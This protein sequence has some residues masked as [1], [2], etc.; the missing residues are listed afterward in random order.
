V[1]FS[2]LNEDNLGKKYYSAKSYTRGLVENFPE[3]E[4]IARNKPKENTPPE[5][6][7]TTDGTTASIIRKTGK[8]VVQQ[9]PTGVVRADGDKTWLTVVAEF[10]YTTEILPYA[11]EEY[12]LI[13]KCW[14]VIEDGLTFGGRP[15]YTPF[16][17]HSGHFSP[18]MVLPYW[19]DIFIQPGKKSGYAC[20]Y[21]FMRSWW[22]PEDIESIIEQEKRLKTQAS[23]RGEKYEGTWDL[24]ALESIKKAKSS[25]DDEAKQPHEEELSVDSD[26]VEI[27]TAFQTGVNACFYTFHPSGG[28]KNQSEVKILRKK[29]NK[30]PRGKMP[31]DWYYGDMDG[32]NPL[33]RGIVELIG[34]LQDLI[35]RNMQ[36]FEFN[37]L[38]AMQPPI[39]KRGSFSKKRIVFAPNVIID[40]GT[41]QQNS[42]D[43]L[44]VDTTA[45]NTYPELYG[46]KK[47]QMLNLVSSPDTSISAEVGNPGFGKT[48]SAI[49]AQQTTVSVDDNYT[50]KMFE[51]TFGNWSETAINLYFAE[52]SGV[53]ELQLDKKTAD[54]LRKLA[55]EEKFDLTKLTD[56]NKIMIDYDTDTPALSF[57]VDAS[58]SKMKD[59]AAQ[60][61]I[62]TDLIKGLES[63]QLLTQ[64][65][66][67]E[68]VLALWNR[69][70]TNSG[71]EDPEDMSIDI[72]EF[73]QQ[74]QQMAE[75]Q[76]AQA[77]AM[78]QPQGAPAGVDPNQ[79]QEGQVVGQ[80]PEQPQQEMPQEQSEAPTAVD[81]LSPD[82]PLRG[83]YQSFIEQ[84]YPPELAVDGVDMAARGASPEEVINSMNE[85]LHAGR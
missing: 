81:F 56:D 49:N 51:A 82:N 5:F 59:D 83:I 26:A 75:Q 66:P 61:Q 78:G 41:D 79:V 84:G 14:S 45:I 60:G 65:V 47:S 23:A 11:N 8:R 24:D 73:K 44:K 18:D 4:R 13:Q 62:L 31:I 10:I 3:Y 52:R 29:Y 32:T 40:L 77:Q 35:D 28:D 74:Q 64:V 43:T 58:T 1:I 27:I 54:Q 37:R 21:I 2:F 48:P 9:L 67:P 68:K 85:V 12:E 76:A 19:G 50:R 71:V 34:P 30:D 20:N 63:S 42:I 80:P 15:I 57:R 70:V 72:E 69:I 55:Q 17:N 53:A 46:L 22:Q 39:I 25:K 33:G 16:I 36:T 38:L 6:P 7:K